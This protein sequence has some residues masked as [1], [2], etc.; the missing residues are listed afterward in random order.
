LWA[1]HDPGR[2]S[3]CRSARVKDKQERNRRFDVDI[4]ELPRRDDEKVD[5]YAGILNGFCNEDAGLKED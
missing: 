3:P 5:T 4:D 1:A 2:L